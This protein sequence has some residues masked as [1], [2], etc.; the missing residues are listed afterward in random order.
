V[1][2]SGQSAQAQ[3]FLSSAVGLIALLIIAVMFS[4]AFFK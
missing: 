3:F 2:K 1:E 4:V